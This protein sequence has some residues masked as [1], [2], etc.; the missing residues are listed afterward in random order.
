MGQTKLAVV[1]SPSFCTAMGSFRRIGDR[2]V[3]AVQQ[4]MAAQGRKVVSHRIDVSELV[5]VGGAEAG[6][7]QRL[8]KAPYRETPLASVRR[9]LDISQMTRQRGSNPL[10][11]QGA[12]RLQSAIRGFGHHQVGVAGFYEG[13][14][15]AQFLQNFCVYQREVTGK[16]QAPRLTRFGKR[17]RNAPQG[18]H[19]RQKVWQHPEALKPGARGPHQSHLATKSTEHPGK[20]THQ[21][22]LVPRKQGFVAPHSAARSP[23]QN[24]TKRHGN[25][26]VALDLLQM[27]FGKGQF[28]DRVKANNLLRIC[29]ILAGM[30]ALLSR[31][32]PAAE[33]NTPD[34][35]SISVRPVVK[36][37]VSTVLVDEESGRLVR[38]RSGAKV[39][40]T[41]AATRKSIL[42]AK[43][44]AK[45][46]PS[47]E[48]AAIHDLIENTARK[49]GVDP[50]LVH[51]VVRVESNY[52]QKAISPKGALGLM[53]LIPATAARFGVENPFDPSQ[54][55][56]GGVRY[57]K[58]L[59]ERFQGNLQLA[60]AAYNAGE[61]AVERHGGIPPYRETQ[62]YVTKITRRLQPNGAGT[63]A[64][65]TSNSQTNTGSAAASMPSAPTEASSLTQATPRQ[66][67]VRMYTDSEGR[68]H[69]ETIQ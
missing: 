65:M 26:M 67:A 50:K 66:M 11:P 9:C 4:S 56:D 33:P 68:L 30:L 22:T 40:S 63:L 57:L 6:R 51:S 43:E 16:H 31:S 29:L 25:R 49:H 46:T 5:G 8:D 53:Q 2:F 47:V 23:H 3:A 27:L 24:V 62:E 19:C 7:M 28:A 64:V 14:P 34:S 58:F 12:E 52:D 44:T 59:T 1:A 21:G 38:V 48:P 42:A 39:R 41:P 55:L 54:N 60:L 17:A 35:P 18:A 69:L 10:M 13:C 36:R 20:M 61:G 37:Q 32:L 15:R 45:K